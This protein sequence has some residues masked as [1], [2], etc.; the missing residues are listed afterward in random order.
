MIIKTQILRAAKTRHNQISI[1]KN[2]RHLAVQW[3]R[4]HTSNAEGCEFNSPARGQRFL[5]QNAPG[6][7]IS[8]E[9]PGAGQPAGGTGPRR[10]SPALA[11]ASP[12]PLR[13]PARREEA[14]PGGL[15]GA[16][17]EGAAGP[18][19]GASPA[20]RASPGPRLRAVSAG[21]GTR[22]SSREPL[23]DVGGVSGEP[24]GGR[25]W[26]RGA[27]V[28]GCR[29][30]GAALRADLAELEGAGERSAGGPRGPG[31]RT[32][33]GPVASAAAPGERGGDGAP[34]RVGTGASALFAGLQDLGVANG[35]DL[36]ETLTNCTE[37]LKAIEQFQVGLREGPGAGARVKRAYPSAPRPR[38]AGHA[39]LGPLRRPAGGSQR[40]L[41]Q[42]ARRRHPSVC[43]F[44]RSGQPGRLTTSGRG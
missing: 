25:T 39:E 12:G 37:P 9:S 8:P 34:G 24:V 17:Q 22:R 36:K 32:A 20:T 4:L 42:P 30:S 43:L 3:L 11:P 1:K 10:S 2:K 5:K 14:G 21:R 19:G 31:E 23:R 27:E 16:A 15:G 29:A 38:G 26:L 28:G 6:E 44:E 7:S 41:L 13:R 40:L 18:G 35:E 33:A